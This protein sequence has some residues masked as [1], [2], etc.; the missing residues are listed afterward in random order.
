MDQ[1]PQRP[2]PSRDSMQS[3]AQLR[4]ASSRITAH[5]P[6]SVDEEEELN[7]SMLWEEEE[8]DCA[9]VEETIEDKRILPDSMEL[10]IPVKDS[11]R[12]RMSKTSSRRSLLP[13]T[14][15]RE[16]SLRFEPNSPPVPPPEG[17]SS[18][19]FDQSPI[20]PPPGLSLLPPPTSTGSWRRR[21]MEKDAEEIL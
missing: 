1:L 6:S 11:V 12:T 7:L 4:V 17:F 3:A 2:L 13:V 15:L 19:R 8:V 14:P 16:L 10:I 21:L 5:R 9:T 18:V 20:A